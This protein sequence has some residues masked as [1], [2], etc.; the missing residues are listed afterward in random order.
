MPLRDQISLI[1]YNVQ[2]NRGGALALET[3][4]PIDPQIEGVRDSSTSS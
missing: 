4:T 2:A 3:P 1:L